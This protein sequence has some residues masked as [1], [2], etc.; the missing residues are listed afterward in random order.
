MEHKT[1]DC[2]S[3]VDGFLSGTCSNS[4]RANLI[5]PG[6][7]YVP[8]PPEG[9]CEFFAPAPHYPERQGKGPTYRHPSSEPDIK[10]PKALKEEWG[11]EHHE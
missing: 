4:Y 1:E 10:V 11:T 9:R 5:D 7:T 8:W 3:C 2:A 6:K